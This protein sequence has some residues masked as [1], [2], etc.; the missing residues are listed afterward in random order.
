MLKTPRRPW[1]FHNL[2]FWLLFYQLVSP[3][4]FSMPSARVIVSLLFSG[5]LFSTV[6]IINKGSKIFISTIFLMGLTLLL[7]WMD[8]FNL[9][10]FS[11]GM[12]S[13]ILCLYLG[14]IVYV[15][16]SLIF[17]ARHITPALISGALCLYLLFGMFWG[18]VYVLL[19]LLHP[20]SFVGALLIDPVSHSQF[21]HSFQ[22]FSLIT[23]TTL[24]YGDIV[25]HTAT[26][27][28]FCQTEAVIG[29]FFMA[30][31]VARLV[32]IQVAAEF[33]ANR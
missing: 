2:L 18:M 19:E 10:S 11:L 26:A 23:L 27:A 15:L 22:Y 28:A 14:L 33:G 29:Q 32:G 13:A 17:S 1:S 20:G 30:V 6:Y 4:L 24:G 31:L 7:F 21:I 9:V 12:S 3:V 8:V 25:P 5:L 16:S